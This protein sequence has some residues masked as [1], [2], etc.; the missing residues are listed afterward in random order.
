MKNKACLLMR[1]L[2][3]KAKSSENFLSPKMAKFWRFSGSE[4]QG[5]E[6]VSIFTA[7]GTSMRGSEPLTAMIGPTGRPVAMRMDH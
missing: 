1:P 6:K 2:V 3:L 5:L 4:G 7:K